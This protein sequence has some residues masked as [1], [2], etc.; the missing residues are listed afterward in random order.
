MFIDYA[1]NDISDPDEMASF[2]VDFKNGGSTSYW[3]SYNNPAAT[4]LVHQAQAEFNTQKRAALYAKIQAIVAQDA[5][6]VPLDYPPYI[7]A[8]TSKV[9]RLRGQPRRRVPPRGRLAELTACHATPGGGCS[10]PLFVVVGVAVGTFLLLHVEPGDPARHVLGQH[11]SP[12][13]I[14]SLRHQWGL[15]SSLAS[16]FRRYVANLAHGDF[17]DSFLYDTSAASL[18]GTRIGKTAALVGVATLV[19]GRH[20]RAARGGRRV[21]PGSP[22]RPRGARHLGRSASA[23]RRSGSASS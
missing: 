20:H 6:F 17:G 10:R 13:A 19:L 12:Q 21:A 5:P 4:K 22:A 1:I 3:S 14:A 7:Y 16:Q 23:C 9:Q 11:A 15:D 8:F 2:E 18:I